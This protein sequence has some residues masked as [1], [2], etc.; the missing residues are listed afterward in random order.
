MM[1]S[2]VQAWLDDPNSNF[3]WIVI[4]DELPNQSSAKRFDSRESSDTGNRPVLTI[5]FEPPATPTPTPITPTHT[6]EPIVCGDVNGD[7]EINVVDGVAIMQIIAGIITPT[8]D[9]VVAADIVQNSTVD[10]SDAILMLQFFVDKVDSL[11]D[12]GPLAP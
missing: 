1:A 11:G 2:D 10:V 8:A 6:P 4:G 12:C 7:G 5:E 9:Q 3:G